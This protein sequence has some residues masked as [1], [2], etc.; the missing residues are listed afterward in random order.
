MHYRVSIYTDIYIDYQILL[1]GTIHIYGYCGP[2]ERSVA[3]RKLVGF[4]TLQRSLALKRSEVAEIVGK[5]GS[6]NGLRRQSI[7]TK[8]DTLLWAAVYTPIKHTQKKK[9]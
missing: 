5:M 2:R 4:R 1:L 8:K 9:G 3:R 7:C 6:R